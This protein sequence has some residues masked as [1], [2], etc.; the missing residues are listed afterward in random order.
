MQNIYKDTMK[1][2]INKQ[3]DLL[4]TTLKLD[5][6]FCIRDIIMRLGGQIEICENGELGEGVEARIV[7]IDNNSSFKISYKKQGIDESYIR[8]AI[9]HELGHLFLHM[10]HKDK[11]GN[12]K[13]DGDYNRK[14]QNISILEWE[15]EEFAA[16]FLMPEKVFRMKVEEAEENCQI[17]DKFQWLAN[18]FRVP[19]KSVITR[20]KSLGIW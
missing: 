19:Y 15:A 4:Y 5:P 7:P 8:F 1:E 9:A 11:Q 20:G 10:A 13:I 16:A 2:I 3:A 18:T 12:Y 6:G 14:T 17:E